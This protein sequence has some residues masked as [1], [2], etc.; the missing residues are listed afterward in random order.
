MNNQHG[1]VI[2]GHCPDCEAKLKPME[3][4]V[5]MADFECPKC[6]PESFRPVVKP[7]PHGEVAGEIGA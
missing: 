4:A 7:D 6:S 1:E 3:G 2:W 5:S